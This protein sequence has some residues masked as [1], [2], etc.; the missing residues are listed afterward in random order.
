L[1]ITIK[2]FEA[3]GIVMILDKLLFD[4]ISILGKSFLIES[5]LTDIPQNIH[6][7]NKFL[8]TVKENIESNSF[9]GA[10]F[11]DILFSFVTDI[12]IRDRNTTSRVF[13]DIFSALFS[14]KS[15][16]VESRQNPP[17]NDEI[18][19]LDSLCTTLDWKI[20][21]DLSGNKREKSDLSLG[22]YEISLKT[23]KGKT[24]D[25]NYMIIDNND[26][27]E[28]NVGSLSYRA[29]LKGIIDDEKLKSLSDR[30]SGLGSGKQLRENIFDPIKSINKEKDFYDRLKLFLEYVY[31][32]DLYIVLKSHYRIDFILIP[33]DT[34]VN[35]LTDLYKENEDK[36][37]EVF[38]RWENNNLRIHWIKLKSY[39]E[40]YCRDFYHLDM[41][42]S[43]RIENDELVK[44]KCAIN[45]NIESIL[46]SK[47]L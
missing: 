12:S 6:E 11:A 43:C 18:K 40:K 9:K 1:I 32:D 8:E 2:K 30:K 20:S 44:F 31:T 42:L 38:Y 45:E 34:F 4:N 19:K 28:L 24:Y 17:V 7:M 37:H 35:T 13:E 46:K 15:T 26:N 27:K 36:F 47:K 25:E 3:G 39:M 29:L 23:L 14:M 22:L 21:T 33:N 10:L 5:G 41:D 16:D